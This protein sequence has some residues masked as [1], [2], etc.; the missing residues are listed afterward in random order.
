MGVIY[1]LKPEIV[2][3]ILESKK[4]DPKLSCRSMAALI[5][6]KFQAKV[7][8]SSIN[9]LFKENSLSMPVGRR[10]TKR[11][12]ALKLKGVIEKGLSPKGT[13]PVLEFPPEVT[14]P[15]EMPAPP[16]S[17][18]VRVA[19]EAKLKAEAEA[20]EEA[21]LKAEA[22]VKAKAEAEAKARAEE[23]ARIKAEEQARLEAEARAKAEAEAQ[24][25]ARRE[26][27]EKARQEA[28]AKAKAEAEEKARKEAE[29]K[30]KLKAERKAKEEAEARAREEA[31]LKAKAEAEEKARIEAEE[32]ARQEAEAEVKAKHEAD[33]RARAEVEAREKRLAEEIARRE[34][35]EKAKFEAA[36]KAQVE[37]ERKAAAEAEAK[38]RAV[39]E[40][41]LKAAK[42]VQTEG[43]F[44]GLGAIL[45][46]SADYLLGGSRFIADVINSRLKNEEKEFLAKTEFFIYNS[47]FEVS[48]VAQSKPDYGLWPLLNYRFSPEELSGYLNELQAIKA[49]P[50]D[51]LRTIASVLQEVRGIKVN[52]SDGTAVYLDGQLHTAWSTV[53]IPYNFSTTIYNIK[54]Y[55][56]RYFQED[57]PFVLFMAPGY[58]LPTKEFFDFILGLEGDEKR[59]MSLGLYSNRFEEIEI[60]RVNPMKKR[61]F[62]FG[63]W[64]WQ[65]AEYRQVKTLGEF[66][67]FHFAP[68]KK[69]FYLANIEL[70]LIQPDANKSVTLRG[71]ALKAGPAEKARLLILSNFPAEKLNLEELAS[72][73]LNRWPN[74]EEAFQDYSRKVELFTYTATSQR[75]FSTENLELPKGAD[76]DI[77]A[78]FSYYLKALDLYARWHLL[79][80]GYEDKDFPTA[81]EQ[82]YGLTCRMEAQEDSLLVTF[83]P[84]AG[85]PYLKALEYA[86]RRL[87][88]KEIIFTGGKRLW[89][90]A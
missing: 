28:E 70:D 50:M 65:F 44:T 79:P 62:I 56:K 88:E 90:L 53:H 23:E 35:E 6:T 45:L 71:C 54:T 74:L 60:I 1:K 52:L 18:E 78:I 73:Y 85:Y 34:A 27:E 7:S 38:A 22:E 46:K 25:K 84:P 76:F 30:A 80:I 3:F 13:V 89:F 43:T 75:F 55:V 12:Y 69:D 58:D 39:E 32:K 51:I 20:A 16:P 57:A 10:R 48:V 19:E 11:K 14:K 26:A 31:E 41:N 47:L 29:E 15:I 33:E 59:I 72:T 17:A 21:K 61:H 24:E 64:P 86:C 68:L 81:K 37:T 63:L 8:K 42:I 66:K 9:A 4:A 49:L 67:P 82:F 36:L 40:A 5:E 2:T 77:S 83:Q 87:N